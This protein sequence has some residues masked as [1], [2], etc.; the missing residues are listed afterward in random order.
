METPTNRQELKRAIYDAWGRYI[1]TLKTLLD[2]DGYDTSRGWGIAAAHDR[3]GQ[4]AADAYLKFQTDQAE[5]QHRYGQFFDSPHLVRRANESY[6]RALHNADALVVAAKFVMAG[7]Q[8]QIDAVRSGQF[9]R[10]GITEPNE[11]ELKALADSQDKLE[12]ARQYAADIGTTEEAKLDAAL[13]ELEKIR[14]G[15]AEKDFKPLKG[16]PWRPLTPNDRL[17]NAMG[18]YDGPMTKR[19]Y[20]RCRNLTMLVGF[21]VSRVVRNNLWRAIQKEKTA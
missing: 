14:P 18:S 17:R 16:V 13:A 5:I 7:A 4:P 20:P 19:G 21:R 10:Y 8:A 11:Q 2:A 6:H 12:E 15:V 3:L 1:G 9:S